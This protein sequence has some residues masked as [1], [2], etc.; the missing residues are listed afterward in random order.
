MLGRCSFMGPEMKKEEK[1]YSPITCLP[2]DLMVEI[3]SR[4]GSS[5]LGSLMN[6]KSSCKEFY[7]SGEDNQVYRCVSLENQPV[8]DWKK[9][10]YASMFRRRC[11]E[12]RN[13][14]A[15]LKLGMLEYFSY[16]NTKTSEELL[17][18]ASTSG[19]LDATY[20][21]GIVLFGRADSRR[22]GTE[23]LNRI[24]AEKLDSCRETS[25]KILRQLWKNVRLPELYSECVEGWCRN[26]G[27]RGRPRRGEWDPWEEDVFCSELWTAI[28]W[29]RKLRKNYHVHCG[30]R[31]IHSL[32]QGMILSL[33]NSCKRTSEIAQCHGYIVKTSLDLL[34]FPLSK[35][36]AA[37]IV[38]MNYARAIFDRIENPTLFNFNTMLRGYSVSEN[39]KESFYLFNNM[40]ALGISLDQFSFVGTLKSCAREFAVQTGECLHGVVL[41]SGFVVFI[42]LMNTLLHFYCACGK[43]RDAHQLFDEFHHF[44][45][46]VSWSVLMAGYL[47]CARPRDVL[48]LCKQLHMAGLGISTA[49][50]LTALSACGDLK[51]IA[52]G[53]S[54]HSFCLKK[55]YCLHMNVVTAIISMYGKSKFLQ[56]ARILFDEF[57]GKDVVLWNSIIDAYCREGLLEEAMT[58]LKLMSLGSVKPNSAT[59]A[60]LLSA[61]ASSG[62]ITIGRCVHNYIQEQLIELDPTLGTALIDMYSKC[63]SIKEATAVFELTPNKDVMCWTAM[64][65]GY[66]LHGQG[67]KALQMLQKM[68]QVGAKP[69]EVTFLAALSACNH[70]GLVIEGKKCFQR[71]IMDYGF[72]P[73]IE[74]FGCMIDLLGRAGLLSEAS[75]LIKNLPVEK[76]ATAWRSF[77]AAC[78]I[79]GDVELGELAKSALMDMGDKH[80]AN[81]ALLQSI[82]T[83]DR[84]KVKIEL[85]EKSLIKKEAGWSSVEINSVRRGKLV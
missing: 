8:G 63:G 39:P 82:Y 33:L 85:L 7:R 43:I 19:H 80:P 26:G 79:H 44:K 6:L 4:V 69:N 65:N 9:S 16:E 29:T 32:D 35:L 70:G 66:G 72:S 52:S 46:A 24:E 75:E 78:R 11:E 68:E 49:A 22:E 13:P 36:L 51:D 21:L 45:D 23:L 47:Q 10:P 20:V 28:R 30:V 5:G 67:E 34:T 12:S 56:S 54:L 25:K 81:L 50:T 71:M 62:D 61:S 17:R 1:H 77:L 2:N 73:R 64:I 37:S 40:R 31:L 48:E 60:A 42:N 38:D 14:E 57:D 76:D 53:K 74:H 58:L 27:R 55:S 18:E 3:S 59:F 41:T 84:R 83:L 15:L